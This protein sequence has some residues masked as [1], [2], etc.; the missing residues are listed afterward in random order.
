MK[1][2]NLFEKVIGTIFSIDRSIIVERKNAIDV[3]ATLSSLGVTANGIGVG[4]VTGNANNIVINFSARNG[5]W[6][7]IK[8]WLTDDKEFIGQSYVKVGRHKNSKYEEL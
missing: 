1:K 6:N 8:D 4:Y 7:A 3:V 2:F 5:L